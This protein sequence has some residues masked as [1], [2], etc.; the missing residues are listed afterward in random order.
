MMPFSLLWVDV[1]QILASR[2]ASQPNDAVA[3]D[4]H[5][6]A[7]GQAIGRGDV[8]G[9]HVAVVHADRHAVDHAPSRA[10]AFDLVAGNGATHR[11]G[12]GAQVTTGAAAELVA[13]HR[14]EHATDDGAAT[15]GAAAGLHGFDAAHI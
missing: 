3:L 10:V 8:D 7:G 15:A 11:A 2:P 13:D 4:A 14:A 6:F 5:A 12:C 1:A 9:A